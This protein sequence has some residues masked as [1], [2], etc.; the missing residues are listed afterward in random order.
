MGK[1]I[2]ARFSEILPGEDDY[3]ATC[4]RVIIGRWKQRAYFLPIPVRELFPNTYV[5]LDGR[6][7]LVHRKM[8]G[9]ESAT[10]FIAEHLKDYMLLEDFP[11]AQQE[12]INIQNRN[13]EK[14]WDLANEF[15]LK[16]IKSG[17]VRDYN[18]HFNLLVSS[19]PYLRDTS[20]F[21]SYDGQYSLP[22]VNQETL[23]IPCKID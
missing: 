18:D 19:H 17:R 4:L 11:K 15:A 2:E 14:R 3:N 13:I 8:L 1:I 10:L 5:N 23:I 12:D 7:R 20:S 16:S 21:E 6:N 9:F 22:S